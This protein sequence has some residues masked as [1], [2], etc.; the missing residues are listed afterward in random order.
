MPEVIPPGRVSKRW[1]VA[2][3]RP[4]IQ[5]LQLNRLAGP[6][7]ERPFRTRYSKGNAIVIEPVQLEKLPKPD[8][9]VPL[10]YAPIRTLF[11]KP[12]QVD[13]DFKS[14]KSMT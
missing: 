5:P 7:A 1:L 4:L 14:V 12:E 6:H 13:V 3:H 11:G 8:V 10:S 2:S 9:F